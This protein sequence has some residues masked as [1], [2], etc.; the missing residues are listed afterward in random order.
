MI[1]FTNL[2]YVKLRPVNNSQFEGMISSIFIEN[3]RILGTYQALR[4]GIVFTNKR[5]IAINVLR[6]N[7]E[8]EGFY[9]I[10]LQ[11]DTSLFD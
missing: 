8:K 9:L 1:D 2:A 10:T 4:D 7:R 11:Q 3:E 6:N 5:I